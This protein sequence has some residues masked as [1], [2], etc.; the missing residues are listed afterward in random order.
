M[1]N[2]RS[3]LAD[4]SERIEKGIAGPTVTV[5]EL[6]SWFD[7]QRRG[8]WVVREI[9][10]VLEECNLVTE[11]NF[12]STWIDGP[13]TIS[14][15]IAGEPTDDLEDPTFRMGRLEAANKEIVSVTPN[16]PIQR[17]TTLMLAND[18]S[19]LP[20]MTGARD[21]KGVVSWKS[22]GARLAL[23]QTCQECQD[24]M[25]DAQIVSDDVSLLDA[26]DTIT[27]YDYVLVEKND[28]TISGLV[29]SSDLSAQFK[30]MS[31]PFLLVGEIENGIRNLLHGRFNRQELQDA[32]HAVDEARQVS[33]PSDLTFGEYIRLLEPEEK[34]AK[35]EL[36]IER[37]EFI[38]Q[39]NRIREIRNDVMHF[40][41]DG[42]DPDDKEFLSGFAKFLNRLRDMGK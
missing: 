5:R 19:Q 6:L 38:R 35:L 33:S 39:L 40:D 25:E 15:R 7:S 32:M 8:Y 18:F 34:W 16:D 30:N 36:N 3:S 12:E 23:D 4:I 21:V 20:V 17:A 10:R 37:K 42:L 27:D 14:R 9:N 24:A 2:P 1:N 13:V 31:E 26:V 29:T 22:I 41:P 28:K 11:P